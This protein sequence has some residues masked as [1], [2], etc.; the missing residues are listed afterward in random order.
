[1]ILNDITQND[2]NDDRY[3]KANQKQEY[4]LKNEKEGKPFCSM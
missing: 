1:M 2:N 4:Y 3:I